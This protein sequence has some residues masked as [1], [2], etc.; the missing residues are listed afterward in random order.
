MADLDVATLT[1]VRRLIV[2]AAIWGEGQPP[3]RAMRAYEE[4][5]A[6]G[7]PR[8]DGALFSFLA[9]GDTA[10]TEFCATDQAPDARLEALGGQRI[11][12][13]VDCDIDFAEPAGCWIEMTLKALVPSEKASHSR[14]IPVD[15]GTKAAGSVDLGPVEAEIIELVEL[16]SSQSE[17]ETIHLELSF[18]GAAPSYNP[19]DSLE[20]Y[21]KNDASYVDD[22]LQAAG[23]SLD[24]ALRVELTNG[25]DVT[26]LSLKTIENYAA[27]T[28]NQ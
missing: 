17:K 9:L 27:S 11:A 7:A 6:E 16:N 2:I 8:L 13:R 19:G 10:Y 22:L 24:A 4:L 20:I 1:S 28:G 25:R 5:M 21:P 14:I 23:L 18:D 15:F 12:E 26:T 3:A